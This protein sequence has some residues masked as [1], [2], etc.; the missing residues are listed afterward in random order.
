MYQSIND[1]QENSITV[2]SKTD[3]TISQK[4]IAEQNERFFRSSNATALNQS[5]SFSDITSDKTNRYTSPEKLITAYYSILRDAANVTD[6]NIGCGTIGNSMQ[7]YPYAYQLLTDNYQK[8][9][10]KAKFTNSFRG[11]AHINLLK[12]KQAYSPAGTPTGTSYYLTEFE[13]I[14][15]RKENDKM[16]KGAQGLFGYYYALFTIVNTG[17]EGFKIDA[18]R[19]VPENYCCAPYHSWKFDAK[20]ITEIVFLNNLKLIDSIESIKYMDDVTTVQASKNNN[21]Y[22]FEYIRLTNGYDLLLHQ[23]E[24]KDNNWVEVNLLKGT[25]FDELAFTIDYYNG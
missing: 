6:F 24:F 22:R 18:M 15:G 9:V 13:V 14:T 10:N 11:I 5:I 23:Y 21:M 25:G 20:F 4:E 1:L 7:P 8:N 2:S 17:R 19:I 16:Q 3:E 12:V